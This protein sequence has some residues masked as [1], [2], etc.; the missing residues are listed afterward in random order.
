MSESSTPG[1]HD[2]DGYA[3]AATL[4]VADTELTV[5]VTLAGNFEPIDGKYHWYGRIQPS[6]ELTSLLDGRQG[7]GVLRTPHGEA[8]CRLTDPDPWGRYRISGTSR[9]PFP[10]PTSLE[11]IGVL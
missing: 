9:P 11:D 7:A 5:T 4:R 1:D 3:G 2:E 10:V 8:D 6:A